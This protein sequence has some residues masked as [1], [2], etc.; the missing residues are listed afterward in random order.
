MVGR[1]Q[2]SESGLLPGGVV[3]GRGGGHLRSRIARSPISRVRPADV[4][5]GLHRDN[6]AVVTSVLKSTGQDI[7]TQGSH[8]S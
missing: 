6:M 1:L 2:G 7:C 3:T 8:D 5:K 4:N